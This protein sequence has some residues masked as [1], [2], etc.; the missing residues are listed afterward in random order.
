[1]V[2]VEAPGQGLAKRGTLRSQLA[3]GKLRKNLRVTLT[4]DE[5]LKHRS[6]VLPKEVGHD[7]RELYQRVREAPL[8]ALLVPGAL[9][10]SVRSLA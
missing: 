3:D 8:E 9:L 7:G 5:R 4:G 2:G 10:N 1:M 6:T